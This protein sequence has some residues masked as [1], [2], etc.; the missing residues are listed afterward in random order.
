VDFIDVVISSGI[1]VHESILPKLQGFPQDYES[2]REKIMECLHRDVYVDYVSVNN[3]L[4]QIRDFCIQ[5]GIHFEEHSLPAIKFLK[6][7]C[8]L[9]FVK[10]S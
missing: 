3:E 2:T 7:K 8:S 5:A 1:V 6:E 10:V 9:K 4:Q